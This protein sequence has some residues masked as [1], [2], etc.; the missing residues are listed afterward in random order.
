MKD[1]S[2]VLEAPPLRV[3]VTHVAELPLFH[4]IAYRIVLG[5]ILILDILKYNG[6]SMRRSACLPYPDGIICR[7]LRHGLLPSTWW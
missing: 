6:L 3:Y 5:D 4:R 7:L 2:G 1:S